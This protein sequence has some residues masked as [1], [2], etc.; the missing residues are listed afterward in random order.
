V[1][2]AELGPA[3][4]EEFYRFGEHVIMPV[5]NLLAGTKVFAL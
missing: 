2:E 4:P 1:R 3:T 5:D